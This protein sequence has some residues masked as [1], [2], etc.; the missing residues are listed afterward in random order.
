MPQN[1]IVIEGINS[2]SKLFDTKEPR[3]LNSIIQSF[4]KNEIK[5]GWFFLSTF[6]LCDDNLASSSE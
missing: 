2:I 5:I 4:F 3:F 6:T 1:N